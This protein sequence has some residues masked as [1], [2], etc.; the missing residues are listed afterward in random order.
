[1]SWTCT[2]SSVDVEA[3]LVGRAEGEPGLEAAAGEEQCVGERVV[4]A[5]DVRAGGGAALA[6]RRAA[7]LAHPDD[8]RLV[9]QARGA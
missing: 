1:M 3:Q 6:E 8:Q 4:V 5:A 9:Q 7:E 2:G